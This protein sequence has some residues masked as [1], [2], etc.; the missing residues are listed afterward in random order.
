VSE[1]VT[2]A[3][4]DGPG[5]LDGAGFL[6]PLS[7]PST[8]TGAWRFIFAWAAGWALVGFAV[9]L[10]ITFSRG[11]SDLRPLLVS[12]V[13]FAEVVGFTALVS[14]RLVFPFY[15][16]LPFALRG[17]LQ[18]FTLVTGTV[19]G[20][21]AI[22]ATQPYYLLANYR[23][24]SVIVLI[25]AVLAVFV[26]IV[27]HTYDAMR[28]QLEANFRAL[29]AK[30]ALEREVEIAREVQRELLP[31]AVPE[32]RGLE[33]AGV[34][35]PAIGVGGDYYDYL[36]LPDERIGLVIAD[37]SGKGIPAALLMAGLQASVRSLT[38]PGIPPCEVCRR[39]N[40]MVHETTSAARYAT[41]F[42]AL[43]DPHDR[44]LVYTN[45]GHFPPL[46][47]GANGPVRLSQGGLPIGL[48]PGSL[49]GEG[50]RELGIGDLLV[51]YTDG[52][53]EQPNPAG[54][55]F[56]EA[57]LVELLARHRDASLS[58]LLN[59]VVEEIRR[60]S[61]GGPPHDDITLVFARTR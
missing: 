16:R 25:N 23:L 44:N 15:V 27:L 37:V 53:V 36:P 4:R 33:L 5:R 38:L 46:H 14:A 29:R 61:A 18:V 34:C 59:V 24:V 1:S 49:Y 32:V 39:L 10:G 41:L 40:D 51:L 48:M 31:R 35:L 60:F 57:R 22:L 47:I 26:G 43:Y 42:F 2:V 11:Q 54:E 7:A 12:S 20:S 8:A 55:E 21:A 45:A 58:D 9:A 28:R 17:V 13:L 19:A 3:Q 30:E 6:P 50:R 52:V 56:G